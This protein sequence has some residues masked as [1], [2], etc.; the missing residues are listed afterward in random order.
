MRYC[1]NC[2]ATLEYTSELEHMRCKYCD[3][4]IILDDEAAKRNRILRAKADAK[5]FA[6]GHGI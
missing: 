5:R 1:P 6:D 2:G 3:T 4:D